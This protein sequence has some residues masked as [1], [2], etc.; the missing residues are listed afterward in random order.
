M[1]FITGS[2]FGFDAAASTAAAAT[3]SEISC[4]NNHDHYCRRMWYAM[5]FDTIM[6]SSDTSNMDTSSSSPDTATNNSPCSTIVVD[7]SR[8]RPLENENENGV[9]KR[10]HYNNNNNTINNNNNHAGKYTRFSL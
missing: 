9:I 5:Q 2:Q 7:S 10:S 1:Q 8:K 6:T 3:V 4:L